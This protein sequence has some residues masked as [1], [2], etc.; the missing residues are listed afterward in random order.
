MQITQV[1]CTAH[2][3]L[4]P[5]TQRCAPS[6]QVRWPRSL[7]L[8]Q[9]RLQH[10]HR[11]RV[12]C[13]RTQGLVGR[14][15]CCP[16]LL[17]RESSPSQILAKRHSSFATVRDGTPACPTTMPPPWPP[18]AAANVSIPTVS[19]CTQATDT[20]FRRLQ[21]SR[22]STV[23]LAQIS[24][25]LRLLTVSP[26]TSTKCST[27]GFLARRATRSAPSETSTRCALPHRSPSD[28]N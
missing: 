8:L 10:P 2:L 3:A 11:C 14:V 4:L 19:R 26:Q 23:W 28:L 20:V 24:H 25:A 16:R 9:P 21:A 5:L 22:T 13:Q 12:L 17:Q 27:D 18:A 15:P 7:W 6:G 1:S